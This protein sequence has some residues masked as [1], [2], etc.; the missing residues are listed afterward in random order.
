[1]IYS[2]NGDV[3]SMKEDIFITLLDQ[4]LCDTAVKDGAA[5][6]LSD[7]C[8]FL[9]SNKRLIPKKANFKQALLSTMLPLRMCGNIP[10]LFASEVYSKEYQSVFFLDYMNEA[11]RTNVPDNFYLATT[12][13]R[14]QLIIITDLTKDEYISKRFPSDIK[15]NEVLT[16]PPDYDLI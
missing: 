14:C 8:L 9:G 11:L 13:A 15:D 4:A 3:L 5:I 2:A 1:M 16:Q 7:H 6:I 10:I 12:R